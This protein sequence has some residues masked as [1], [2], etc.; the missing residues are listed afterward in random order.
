MGQYP[1]GLRGPLVVHDPQDPFEG[2]YDEEVIFTVSDW[3]V[4]SRN[5]DNNE[6]S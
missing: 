4:L 6:R 2:K 1:D 3:Y 5:S